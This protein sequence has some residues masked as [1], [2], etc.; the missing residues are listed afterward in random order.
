MPADRFIHPRLGHSD[1]VC[2]LTDLEARVWAMGYLIA[3]DDYGVMRCSAITIQSANEALAKRPAKMIDRCLQTLIDVGLLID[4]DHQ[5]R[6]YVCQQDWQYWQKV[7]YPRESTNP[8]PPS[9]TIQRCCEE[10]R[11]LFQLRSSNVPEITLSPAGA[12]GRER[13]MANGNR[14]T[15]EGLRQRFSE[16]WRTYPKKVGKDAAWRA[17]QKRRPDAALLASMLTA[18]G[19][20]SRQENWLKE[21]GQYVPNP[22]T[23]LN[24]GRWEDEPPQT[25][26]QAPA[27]SKQ[28][29][30]LIAAVGMLND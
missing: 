13:L 26:S 29:Q 1:K 19:W 22:A 17:W 9:E 10:T 7:R 11:E 15:A 6:R 28:T 14:L 18:L 8:T 27:M 20:Q 21:N 16:F 30:R 4:F 25:Q 5:G 3:A 23:W 2:Q 24:A 12:G